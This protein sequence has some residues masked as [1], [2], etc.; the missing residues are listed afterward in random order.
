MYARHPYDV[1][2]LA[3]HVSV[4]RSQRAAEHRRAHEAR[5]HAD[6]RHAHASPLRPV[7]RLFVRLGIA[8]GGGPETPPTTT[9]STVRPR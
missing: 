6:R 4:E 7:G 5:A 2:A 3:N 1:W 8:L 9:L